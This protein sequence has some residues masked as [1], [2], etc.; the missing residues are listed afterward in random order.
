MTDTSHD[1]RE[2][3]AVVRKKNLSLGFQ[4]NP[5]G[6]QKSGSENGRNVRKK[7]L[8]SGFK[9]NRSENF[10]SLREINLARLC[11]QTERQAAKVAGAQFALPCQP[12]VIR[13]LRASAEN[14]ETARTLRRTF[15]ECAANRGISSRLGIERQSACTAFCLTSVL[16]SG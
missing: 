5:S 16:M 9:K 15:R 11:I 4:K 13:M 1:A 7:N 6:K 8:A 14:P 3:F 2:T 12:C 10:C